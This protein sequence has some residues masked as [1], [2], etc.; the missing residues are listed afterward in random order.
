M[1]RTTLKRL[2]RKLQLDR[3]KNYKVGI[4]GQICAKYNSWQWTDARILIVRS[5][6]VKRQINK[7]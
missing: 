2:C 1:S 6:T 5:R 4:L 3:M 7:M